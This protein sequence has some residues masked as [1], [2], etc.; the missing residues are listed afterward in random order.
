MLSSRALCQC[1]HL[2]QYGKAKLLTRHFLRRSGHA[3]RYNNSTSKSPT[4]S[5]WASYKEDYR[6]DHQR[7]LSYND[8]LAHKVSGRVF[9]PDSILLPTNDPLAFPIIE[10]YNLHGDAAKVPVDQTC[11]VKLIGLSM[12]GGFD[13]VVS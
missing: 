13:Y 3:L 11:D 9:K 7:I 4:T 1:D 6:L 2:L 10:G 12:R 8:P 5:T